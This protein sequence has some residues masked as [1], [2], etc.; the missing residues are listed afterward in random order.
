MAMVSRATATDRVGLDVL[1]EEFVGIE[2]R[3][4]PRQVENPNLAGLLRQPSFH[5]GRPVRRM[6]VDDQ[7]RIASDLPNKA[8]EEH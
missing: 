5:D 1:V 4:I 7:E 6:P 3:A 2:L 8:R